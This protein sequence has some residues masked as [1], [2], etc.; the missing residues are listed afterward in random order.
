M[1]VAVPGRHATTVLLALAALLATSALCSPARAAGWS[2]PID[3][4]TTPGLEDFAVS[5]LPGTDDLLVVGRRPGDAIH[6]WSTRLSGAT[7]VGGTTQVATAGAG[8]SIGRAQLAVDA[9]GD[10]V[11]TWPEAVPGPMFALCASVLVAGSGAWTDAHCYGTAPH[12][13]TTAWDLDPAGHAAFAWSDPVTG[14]AMATTLELSTGAVSWG[15]VA[16]LSTNGVDSSNSDEPMAAA[17]APDG[18][19]VVAWRAWNGAR[20]IVEAA[21]RRAGTWGAAVEEAPAAAGATSTSDFPQLAVDRRCGGTITLALATQPSPGPALVSATTLSTAGS[22][23]VPVALT[24][25]ANA[26]SPPRVAIRG[27][28]TPFVVWRTS[29]RSAFRGAVPGQSD[30]LVVAN[31]PDIDIANSYSHT[32]VAGTDGSITLAWTRENARPELTHVLRAPAGVALRDGELTQPFAA[33]LGWRWTAASGGRSLLASV[34]EGNLRVFAPDPATPSGA[35][36]SCGAA[37]VA[38]VVDPTPP[39]GPTPP[40]GTSPAPTPTTPAP[41]TSPTPPAPPTPEQV[42]AAVQAAIQLAVRLAVGFAVR[43]DAAVVARAGVPTP[44]ITGPAGSTFI[45]QVT[46]PVDRTGRIQLVGGSAIA[47]PG[48][49]VITLGGGNVITAGGANV[50]TAGGANV[51]T[52]GGA[53]VIT[54]GGGNVIT[55]GGGNLTGRS[56]PHR[57]PAGPVRPRALMLGTGGFTFRAAGRHVVPTPLTP[58]GR[59]LVATLRRL[60][61]QARHAHRR[62]PSLTITITT[63]AGRRDGSIPAIVAVHRLRLVG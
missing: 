2:Q 63:V 41:P 60:G 25:D 62:P 36:T 29:D 12:P 31:A 5:D 30:Q 18:T 3:I 42:R 45:N 34:T 52:A 15:D 8:G 55:A 21:V 11:A 19:A 40:A 43:A 53:N 33:E 54:A 22:F 26:A 23:P 56:R 6:L 13:R 17:V 10:A 51:I 4:G 1:S 58:G 38:P 48:A 59:R 39:V 7:P 57:R 37:G 16:T 35:V 14:H 20:W 50:I 44:P 47:A 49:N 27:D 28:G 61:A 24:T 46:I 32:L 9:R